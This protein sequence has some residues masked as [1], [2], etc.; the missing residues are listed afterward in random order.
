MYVVSVETALL[1]QELMPH[2]ALLKDGM[3]LEFED[4]LGHAMFV[5]HQW[6]GEHHPDPGM[7][8]F[9]ELQV[10]LRNVMAGTK[11]ISGTAFELYS[12]QQSV[13]S[14][15]ELL[16]QP[17]FLWYDFFSCPQ[18][19]DSHRALAIGSIPAYVERCRFF[20]AL[21]P[22]IWHSASGK[23]LTRKSW[24]DRGWCRLERAARRLSNTDDTRVIEIQSGHQVAVAPVFSWVFEPVGEGAFTVEE[25]RRQL[26]SVV[27]GMVRKKLHFHLVRGNWHDYRLMLNLQRAQYRNLPINPIDDMIPGF[28]SDLQDP[29]AFA[30][31]SFLHQNGFHSVDERSP[32]GWTPICYAAVD[33]NPLLL[34][35]LLEMR[36]DVNDQVWESEALFHFAP[37]TPLLHIC[38][39]LS[40]HEALDVL[41]AAGAEVGA[42]DGYGATALTW[43]AASNS[44]QCIEVLSAAGAELTAVNML[45]Y[46]PFLAASAF[47]AL[48]AMKKLMPTT[49]QQEIDMALHVAILHGGGSP[50]VILE[51]V[52]A[53]A[54]INRQLSTPLLSPLGV[55]FACLSMRHRWKQ[56][57]LSC[58]AYHHYGATPLMCSVITSSFDA[59]AVLLAAGALVDVQNTRGCT[60]MDL[61]LEIGAP[62]QIVEALE[63]DGPSRQNLIRN[64]PLDMGL[65][66]ER[67]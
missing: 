16:I 18:W 35:E 11:M 66:S 52:Q 65:I 8:Q 62:D 56:S 34:S 57:T 10:S 61:A 20:V 30:A 54:D 67:F 44:V 59:V 38:A 47:G 43:A 19:S 27:Q 32:E 50:E 23:P 63:E 14:S 28:E 15:E 26:A 21:C 41:I 29:A 1:M 64:L 9:K 25:D 42:V 5:S 53:E 48:P 37:K 33:G 17:L 51:L 7:A 31:A 60:A 36:A 49:T 45:G 4:D 46:S 22:P 13:I 3:L 39:A 12:G 40:H 6:A 58:Y 55:L 2:E 24:T